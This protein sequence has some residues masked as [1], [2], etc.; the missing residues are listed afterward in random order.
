MS[1]V[2]VT[3]EVLFARE[4]EGTKELFRRS[5]RIRS[6]IEGTFVP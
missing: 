3:S 1:S 6:K 5:G 2:S 4:N